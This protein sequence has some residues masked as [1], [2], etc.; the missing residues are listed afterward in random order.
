MQDVQ[1][2]L[3]GIVGAGAMGQGIAQ[4]AAVAGLKVRLMDG[5]A[6]A[7]SRAIAAIDN[8]LQKLSAKGKLTPEQAREALRR[9]PLRSLHSTLRQF[10]SVFITRTKRSG[11][12][13]F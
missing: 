12:W 10:R 6:A 4:I 13:L 1:E 7:S 5:D 9:I 11:C 3:I 8:M 2:P